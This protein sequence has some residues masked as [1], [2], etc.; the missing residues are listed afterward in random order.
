MHYQLRFVLNHIIDSVESTRFRW[1]HTVGNECP[2]P[3]V[4]F[5]IFCVVKQQHVKQEVA[6][7]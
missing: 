5:D 4:V 2:I 1:A 3:E 6:S 7:V